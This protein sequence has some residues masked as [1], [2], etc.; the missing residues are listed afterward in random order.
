M[1]DFYRS[2]RACAGERQLT[3]PEVI[4]PHLHYERSGILGLS[5]SRAVFFLLLSISKI[6]Y[7]IP[8]FLSSGFEVCY[9]P[10][11]PLRVCITA[12]FGVQVA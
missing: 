5:P 7:R 11:L 4:Q 3:A 12:P 9:T 1:K 6:L 2:S 10:N 8:S